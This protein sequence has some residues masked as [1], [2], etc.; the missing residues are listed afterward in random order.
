MKKTLSATIAFA[1]ACAASVA[2]PSGGIEPG[3]QAR[4]FRNITLAEAL[5]RAVAMKIKNVQ[6]CGGQKISPENDEKFDHNMSEAAKAAVR[7]LFET[8]GLKLASYGVVTGKNEDDWRKIF[9]FARE[10]GLLDIATE[11]MPED[12]PLVAK[13]SD[14]TGVNVAIHNHPPPARCHDPEAA[15]AAARP[16]GKNIGLCAD[17]GHWARSGHDP[18]ATLRK[19]GGRIISLHLKDLTERGVKTAHDM[20][21]GTGASDAALQI[22]ELRRQG[23]RGIVYMEYECVVPQKQLDAETAACADWFRRAIVASDDDLRAGRVLPAGYVDEKN[24]GL[25]WAGK[26]GSKS[27]RWPAPQPL[28]A[29][30]LS[31]ADMKPGAW[32]YQDG[33]LSA[34]GGGDIWTKESYGD[35]AL[36]LDFRCEEKSNSGVF[37][38]CSDI[39]DWLHSAIEVQILQGDTPSDKGLA[40]AI[41]D[42]AAPSRQVDIEPGRWYHFTIIAQG[43]KIQ[44][45]IDGERVINIDLSQWKEA[46]ENPDGTKNKFRKAYAGMSKEGRIG[47][48]YHRHPPVFFRNLVVERIEAATEKK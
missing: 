48:Q 9:A 39:V 7:A 18:A 10:M 12:M 28:F 30:D 8:R 37:L 2:A 17:T 21:W 22:L 43:R 27:E 33:I 31:N 25:E 44:V 11:P 6:A 41:C 3:L 4:T 14:E 5:D 36:N 16:Y 46:G 29:A 1:A 40:G 35:F 13:L 24:V 15:L 19:A 38:R 42:I 26:R 23:F 45:A 20:P 32:E 34:K 47:L